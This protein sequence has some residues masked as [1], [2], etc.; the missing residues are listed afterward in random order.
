MYHKCNINIESKQ[1]K[2]KKNSIQF[3]QNDPRKI[4]FNFVKE[5]RLKFRAKRKSEKW[6]KIQKQLYGV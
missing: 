1:K 5:R 4:I 6:N 3:V 2:K